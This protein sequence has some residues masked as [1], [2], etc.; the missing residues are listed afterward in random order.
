MK[1][2]LSKIK[3]LKYV[4]LLISVFISASIAYLMVWSDSLRLITWM[5]WILGVGVIGLLHLHIKAFFHTEVD[6]LGFYYSRLYGMFF[7]FIL[8]SLVFII[9]LSF[10]SKTISNFIGFIF[11]FFVICSGLYNFFLDNFEDQRRKHLLGK[12]MIEKE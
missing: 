9:I 11:L 3:H 5:G 4:A 7:S 10:N 1:N 6:D 2:F 12:N 8:T